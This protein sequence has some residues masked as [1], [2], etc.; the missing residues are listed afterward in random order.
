MRTNSSI[1][2]DDDNGHGRPKH[3][4]NE[5]KP[6]L[7]IHVDSKAEHHTDAGPPNDGRQDGEEGHGREI[8]DLRTTG[9]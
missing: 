7:H 4:G 8:R 2:G 1:D 5:V 6:V 9:M 3:P